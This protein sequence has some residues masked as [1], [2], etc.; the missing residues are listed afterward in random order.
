MP[1]VNSLATGLRRSIQRQPGDQRPPMPLA[2]PP[3][4]RGLAR[5]ETYTSVLPQS[6]IQREPDFDGGPDRSGSSNRPGGMPTGTLPLA[7]AAPASARTAMSTTALQSLPL[8]PTI[9]RLDGDET[10]TT[11]APRVVRNEFDSARSGRDAMAAHDA[12]E[13]R[14]DELRWA[15]ET[16]IEDVEPDVEVES[17]DEEPADEADPIKEINLDELADKIL[18]YIRRLMAIERERRHPI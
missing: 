18:P 15:S 10:T 16:T 3:Q 11:T 4:L 8:A 17:S 13:R 12:E 2:G 9:Q 6:R 1:R 14:L 7:P 5:T